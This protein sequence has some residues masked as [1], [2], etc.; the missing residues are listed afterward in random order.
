MVP[1]TKI[2]DFSIPNR[3]DCTAKGGGIFPYSRQNILQ[4]FFVELNLRS[5]T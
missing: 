5:K 3:L 4:E 1:E 2:K